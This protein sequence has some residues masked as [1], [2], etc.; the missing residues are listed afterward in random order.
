VKPLK[1]VLAAPATAVGLAGAF[2]PQAGAD[3]GEQEFYDYATAIGAHHPGGPRAMVGIGYDICAALDNGQSPDEG[4]WNLYYRPRNNLTVFQAGALVGNAV[5]NL[6]PEYTNE[7]KV[8]GA[9]RRWWGGRVNTIASTGGLIEVARKS[10]TD[11]RGSTCLAPRLHHFR[12]GGFFRSF[13]QIEL[14]LPPRLSYAHGIVS[15][16]QISQ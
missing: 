15:P 3:S 12:T 2:A 1:R 7:L 13:T 16:Q 10:S 14:P 4:G 8:S 9:P 5:K 6:W 11:R